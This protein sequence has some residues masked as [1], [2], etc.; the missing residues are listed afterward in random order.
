MQL[1]VRELA[2]GMWVC[3]AKRWW[4]KWRAVEVVNYYQRGGIG[5]LIYTHGVGSPE[6]AWCWK[7]SEHKALGVMRLVESV[8]GR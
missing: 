1:R 7:H 3:E 8:L 6:Y 2:N 5:K 4:H